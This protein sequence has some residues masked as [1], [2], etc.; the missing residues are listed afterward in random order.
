LDK[1]KPENHT[2]KV[3]NIKSPYV[4]VIQDGK[5]IYKDKNDAI[6]DLIWKENQILKTHYEENEVEMRKRWK[7]HK[8]EIVKSWLERLDDE[9]EELWKRLKEDSFLVLINNKEVIMNL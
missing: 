4:K 8:L 3:T 6:T 5:W 2:I 7:E 9:D 1:D